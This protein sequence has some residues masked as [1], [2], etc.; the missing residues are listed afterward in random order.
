MSIKAFLKQ[1]VAPIANLKVAVSQRFRDENGDPME[2]ELRA[3]SEDENTRLKEDCTTRKRVKG[4][5]LITNFNA[6]L[7]SRKLCTASIVF[8]SLADAELQASYAVTDS[9]E[10][11]GAMLLPGEFAELSKAAQE[12]NGFDLEDFEEAKEEAKNS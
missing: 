1:N 2:W 8:P 6:H 7:Y 4:G 9:E 11:L 12:I 3:I 10:L 5:R